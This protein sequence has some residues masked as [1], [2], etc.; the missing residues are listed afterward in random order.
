[1]LLEK[2]KLLSKQ[3]DFVAIF[4][5]HFKWITDSLNLFSWFENTSMWSGNDTI[6]S[7][8]KKFAFHQSIKPI[9]QKFK[10]KSKFSFNYVSIETIKKN[11]IWVC[12]SETLKTGSFPEGI[13]CA[14]VRPIYKQ[15]NLFDKKNYRLV[16]V[17]PLL[18]KF[19]ERV[20]HEQG[21]IILILFSM[22][23]SN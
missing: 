19:Y 15:L 23:K 21:Q 8:T 12:V 2:D 20:I 10:I 3:K 6:N 22:R 5:K 4:D 14:N 9:N 18:S 13:K 7:I 16:S 17:L 11:H 1:M